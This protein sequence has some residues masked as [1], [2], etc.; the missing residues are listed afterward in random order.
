[1]RK[2][3]QR[4]LRREQAP[5]LVELAKHHGTDK[6]G[7]HWYAENYEHHFSSKRFSSLNILEIGVGG[8]DNPEAGGESLRMWKDFFPRGTV[9]G[10]DIYDKQVH[11]ED[12]IRIYQGNQLNS[13]IL[14]RISREAE[15]GLD[16]VIDDGSHMNADV[17]T[18]FQR[19]FPLMNDDG[20]Y[21]IEDLQTSYW[22]VYGGGRNISPTSMSML[23]DM[24]DGLNY[25]EF[26]APGYEPSYYDQNIKSLHFYHNI[27]FIYKGENKEGSNIMTNNSFNPSPKI[28]ESD[29]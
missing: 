6:W 14:E 15:G 24:V 10:L 4:K 22:P 11:A 13:D 5:S 17:I 18:S 7:T 19:L 21:V 2:Y 29:E 23:K 27:A 12:R 20:I 3:N 9:Y 28:E 16:I 8:Y 25:E 26:D 1:M